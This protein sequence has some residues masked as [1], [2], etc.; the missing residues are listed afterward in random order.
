MHPLLDLCRFLEST[1]TIRTLNMY[2]GRVPPE[3]EQRSFDEALRG[4]GER[5]KRPRQRHLKGLVQCEDSGSAA[6]IAT[7]A[8]SGFTRRTEAMAYVVRAS[9]QRHG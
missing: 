5:Y 7:L 6:Q 4:V 1:K 8:I 3:K 2:T 9:P